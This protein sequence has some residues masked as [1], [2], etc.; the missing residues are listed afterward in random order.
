MG[1]HAQVTRDVSLRDF[2]IREQQLLP[3]RQWGSGYPSGAWA[4]LLE[5]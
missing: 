3:S 4:P 2:A 5:C 1:V